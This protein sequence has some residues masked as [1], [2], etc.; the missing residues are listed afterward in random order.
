MATNPIESVNKFVNAT[1]TE[2]IDTKITKKAAS[3]INT[4]VTSSV[5]VVD[6]FLKRVKE[7]TKPEES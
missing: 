5:D 1:V 7:M 6:D 2:I 3:I 4:V